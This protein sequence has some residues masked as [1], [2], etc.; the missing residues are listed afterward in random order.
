[1][2]T[3]RQAKRDLEISNMN[4]I[5]DCFFIIFS[6]FSNNLIGSISN[7]LRSNLA[8]RSE[9]LRTIQSMRIYVQNIIYLRLFLSFFL[10]STLI[11]GHALGRNNYSINYLIKYLFDTNRATGS[12]VECIGQKT[13][14]DPRR[15][16]ETS[17]EHRSILQQIRHGSRVLKI[18]GCVYA[19]FTVIV[20]N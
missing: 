12:R 4:L 9:C 19:F 7:V 1:V 13:N 3:K 10:F 6:L 2:F 11:F 8:P 17:D 20:I 18:N 5:L 14:R 16:F 15:S